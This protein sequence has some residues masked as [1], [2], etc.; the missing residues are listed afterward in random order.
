MRYSVA[1]KANNDD[2]DS[3]NKLQHE[4]WCKQIAYIFM[5][6]MYYIQFRVW[7][8]GMSIKYIELVLWQSTGIIG[9]RK[10]GVKI[11]NYYYY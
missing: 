7:W 10:G 4:W 11:R 8:I 9:T 5:I 2:D 6:L 1:S 3:N